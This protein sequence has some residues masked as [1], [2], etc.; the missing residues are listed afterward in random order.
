MPERALQEP[1][2]ILTVMA[3]NPKPEQA[4]VSVAVISGIG[5]TRIKT[6]SEQ[7]PRE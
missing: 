5:F 7:Y 3:S 4:D 2:G 1:P 6:V